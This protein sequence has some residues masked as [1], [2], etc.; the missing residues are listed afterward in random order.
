MAKG[1]T[2]KA[3]IFAAVAIGTLAIAYVIVAR[4]PCDGI[5]KQVAPKLSVN[6]DFIRAKG[7]WVIGQE[8][9]QDISEN[10]RQLGE[11][12][13]TCCI[14]LHSG[15]MDAPQFQLCVAGAK[16]FEAKTTQLAG[17][18]GDAQSAKDHGDAPAVDQKKKEATAAADASANVVRDL[19]NV[20]S[21]V[22]STPASAS[23]LPTG[24]QNVEITTA[25][26]T[27]TLVRADS[28]NTSDQKEITL[29]YGQSIPFT[30]MRSI[31]V[32]T[33]DGGVYLKITLD[34]GTALEGATANWRLAGE[35]S[36]GHFEARLENIKHVAFAR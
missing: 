22:A 27:K 23:P 21:T 6:M 11:L 28:L 25:D 34:D 17:A 12:L 7:E 33:K 36:V 32:A 31:D 9:V 10:A 26:G 24:L 4:G 35:N 8:K 3:L 14:S 13:T 15:R 30:R 2:L 20:A 5:L 19:K 18:V 29:T 1:F 16:D